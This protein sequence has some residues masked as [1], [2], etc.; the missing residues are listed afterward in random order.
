M[1]LEVTLENGDVLLFEDHDD[2]YPFRL[3]ET[4]VPWLK[5]E[6]LA[7]LSLTEPAIG[8]ELRLSVFVKDGINPRKLH[9]ATGTSAVVSPS[10]V[11]SFR[12][13]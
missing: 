10:P 1:K 6:R 2:L 4:K 12:F 8:Q 13:V 5:M 9:R 3:I 11:R 7:Y